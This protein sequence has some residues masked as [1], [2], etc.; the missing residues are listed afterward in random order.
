LILFD[1][2]MATPTCFFRLCDGLNVLGPGSGTIWT[3]GLVEIGVT[4]LE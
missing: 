4:W 2:R 1:I 3:C